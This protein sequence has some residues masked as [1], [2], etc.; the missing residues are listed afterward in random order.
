MNRRPP[1][2]G[3]GLLCLVTLACASVG[4]AEPPCD[5]SLRPVQGTAGYAPRANRCEGLYVSP[6][7][8]PGLE[9]VSLLR[10]K[11][12]YDLQPQ[13]RLIVQAPSSPS[14]GSGRIQIRAVA[15]PLKTYYRMD[16][17]LADSRQMVWPVGEVLFPLRL[18][19]A[20]IGAFGWVDNAGGRLFLPLRVTSEGSAA[21]Q[22]PIEPIEIGIRA[23][24]AL[25]RL[26]WRV[27]D[28]SP[29]ARPGVWDPVRGDFSAGK[30]ITISLPEGPAGVLLVEVAG[31]LYGSQEWV[32]LPLRLLR[33]PR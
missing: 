18:H 14:V 8:A 19:Q 25:D 10:G 29:S 2:S 5:A 21:G 9:L 4:S 6:I 22:E 17:T 12:R 26:L 13:A 24:T 23:T 15:L 16:A 30:I 3:L 7:S 11:I 31:Q 33:T 20:S 28:E 1:S 32:R 27:A